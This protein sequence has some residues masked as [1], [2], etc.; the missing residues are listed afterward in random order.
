MDDWEI[1]GYPHLFIDGKNGKCVVWESNAWDTYPD[2]K[3]QKIKYS[4]YDPE[5]KRWAIGAVISL[6][7]Q[8]MLNQ[9]PAGICDSKGTK[10]VVWSGR[11]RDYGKP[12]GIY[13]AVE[14]NG[15]WSKPALISE[16]DENARAPKIAIDRSDAVW[17]SWHSGI[18]KDMKIKVLRLNILD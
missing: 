7:E 16:P 1:G 14:R 6:D 15:Q 2:K 13:L 10:I 3:A 5:Q 8:T 11:G 9:T 4:Q 12:W 17:V 18:G